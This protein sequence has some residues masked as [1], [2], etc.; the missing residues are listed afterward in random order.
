MIRVGRGPTMVGRAARGQGR[1][2]G[3]PLPMI[4]VGRGPTM[5][6]RAARGQGRHTGRPLPMIRVGRGPTM[7]GLATQGRGRHTGRPLPV[8]RVGC[9]P[10][11][12]E[13]AQVLIVG[14]GPAGLAAA[15][16]LKRLGVREVVV[17]EREGQAG[18]VPR[19]CHHTGFGLRDLRRLLSGPSYAERYRG[20]AQAAGVDVRTHTT[21]TGWL[22]L[23]SQPAVS[24]QRGEMTL[25]YTSPRGLGQ[26]EAEAVLLATG[27]R[28]R[29]RS[30]RLVPGSR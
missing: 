7:A 11:P 27:C 30:A 4:R 19:L 28:E 15:I 18:G 16:E 14:G 12:P 13:R 17:A 1:H 25:T 29:P 9:G 6:G 3:R 8:I 20:A 24:G 22:P 21:I 10:M 5:V 26:I 2:T 23:T